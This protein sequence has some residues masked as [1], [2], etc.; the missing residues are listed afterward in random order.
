MYADDFDVKEKAKLDGN[1]GNY[2]LYYIIL[3]CKLNCI[4]IYIIF[5]L[6][7]GNV[8]EID[9]S[10]NEHK[11]EE[12]MWELKWSQDENAE[13]HGPHT[14]EQMHAWAKEGYFKSGA[15]V[16]RKGQNN[17]FYNAARVDF[18]LYL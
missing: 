14:S 5:I 17:Q 2:I 9:N 7:L 18:E 15:W 10:E 12:I 4:Y 3:Y 13:I 11:E 8:N 6:F 1:E 16:R